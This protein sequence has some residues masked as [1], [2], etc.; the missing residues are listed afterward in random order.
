MPCGRRFSVDGT[1][2]E[3]TVGNVAAGTFFD[4]GTVH[5]DTTSSLEPLTNGMADVPLPGRG[6]LGT[7]R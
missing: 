5:L 2:E 4:F 7:R 3:I 1:E 6:S